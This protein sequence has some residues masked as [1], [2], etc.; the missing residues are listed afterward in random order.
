VSEIPAELFKAAGKEIIMELHSVI[1]KVWK[2]EEMADDWKKEHH[3]PN[4]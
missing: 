3:L 1:S 4:I 2:S